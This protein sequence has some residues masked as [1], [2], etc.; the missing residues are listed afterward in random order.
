[1]YKRQVELT[2]LTEKV[3]LSANDQ[4]VIADSETTPNEGKRVS[5]D[6]ITN[7]VRPLVQTQIMFGTSSGEIATWAEGNSTEL[8]PASKFDTSSITVDTSNLVDLT[9]NQ[10]ITGLKS[11]NDIRVNSQQV[12]TLGN[13]QTVFGDKTFTGAVNL[14]GTCLL[15]TSPSP[16]DS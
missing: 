2:S 8:I 11:F 5:L 14:N 16:R 6:S 1:M 4:F 10:T 12:M 13:D 7:H 3:A 9:S 15:Y